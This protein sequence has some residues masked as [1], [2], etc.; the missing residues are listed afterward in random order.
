[1]TKDH[2][3]PLAPNPLLEQ[4][5][6]T[7]F[8]LHHGFEPMPVCPSFRSFSWPASSVAIKCVLDD[9]FL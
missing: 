2:F 1:M 4:G 3:I 6:E 7:V 9:G 8:N 5:P